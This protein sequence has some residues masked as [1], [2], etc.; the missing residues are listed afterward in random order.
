VKSTV[1][2]ATGLKPSAPAQQPPR[3][4][5]INEEEKEEKADE[6]FL[7]RLSGIVKDDGKPDLEAVVEDALPAGVVPIP[8]IAQ[9]SPAAPV[10]EDPTSGA[11]LDRL[12]KMLTS[13][14]YREQPSPP[15]SAPAWEPLPPS[16]RVSARSARFLRA[17][18]PWPRFRARRRSRHPPV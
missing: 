9:A 2:R 8:Q 13:G 7:E 18:R 16:P 17:S 11:F 15:A 10:D 14:V 4:V 3:Q 1:D 6:V 5:A 12:N